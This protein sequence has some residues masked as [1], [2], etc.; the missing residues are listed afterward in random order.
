VQ[1]RICLADGVCE[2]Q[3]ARPLTGVIL[4]NTVVAGQEYLGVVHFK[5]EKRA[6]LMLLRVPV[7]DLVFEFPLEMPTK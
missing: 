5:R 4:L 7:G 1:R 6:T 2:Y 3:K